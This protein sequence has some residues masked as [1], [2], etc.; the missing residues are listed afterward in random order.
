VCFYGKAFKP[1][2]L[3]VLTVNVIKQA[4]LAGEVLLVRLG[5]ATVPFFPRP[6]VLALARLGG[7]LGYCLARN[8][9]RIALT[10]L[11][12]AFKDSLSALEKRRIARQ[13]FGTMALT[14]LDMIWFCRHTKSRLDRYV[15]SDPQFSR[16]VYTVPMI[17]LTAHFGNWELLSRWL[18]ANNYP[19]AA[20]VAPLIN[21]GVERLFNRSR[22]ESGMEVIPQAGALRGVLKTLKQKKYVALVLDQNVRTEAGGTFVNFFGLPVPMSGAAAMFAE[23]TGTPIVVTFCMSRP[24]G[25]YYV[26]ALPPLRPESFARPDNTRITTQIVAGLFEQEIR[27]H[28]GQWLWMYKRWKHIPPGMS[29]ADYPFYAKPR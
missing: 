18:V 29:P 16:H 2:R 10:N 4:R 7:A 26:Y 8:S 19:H 11:D 9:R 14:V 25:A 28:P 17:G 5:M 21:P 20:V 24:D 27:K 15:A 13:A 1:G 12:L 23:R 6:V 3:L 22:V